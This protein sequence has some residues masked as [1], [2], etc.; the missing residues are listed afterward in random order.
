[1]LHHI[2]IMALPDGG[3]VGAVRAQEDGY[4]GQEG[5]A[6]CSSPPISI[7]LINQP[8]DRSRLGE[9]NSDRGDAKLKNKSPTFGI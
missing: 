5:S 6:R 8:N 2:V 1:M 3:E 4:W 7:S 9:M